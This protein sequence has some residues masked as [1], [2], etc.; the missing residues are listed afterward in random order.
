MLWYGKR[1]TLKGTPLQTATFI[2]L[3]DIELNFIKYEDSS[4][5]L[6]II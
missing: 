5:Y 6:G 3:Y 4:L 2:F 1:G